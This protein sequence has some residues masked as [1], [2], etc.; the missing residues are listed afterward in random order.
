[1]ASL[2]RGRGTLG[3][4]CNWVAGEWEWFR[5]N[6]DAGWQNS[7]RHNLSLNKAF[8]K[9]PR[10]PEDDPESKGSVWIIDP[11]EGPLFEEKQKR[12]AAKSEGKVKNAEMK[13]ER[14]RQK[15]EERAKKQREMV[16][17]TVKPVQP[18][19]MQAQGQSI[20]RAMAAGPRPIQRPMAAQTQSKPALNPKAKVT[21]S[22]QAIT[23]ALRAKSV[24]ATTDSQ[25]N[26]LPFVCDGSSL[27]LDTQTFGH[28]TTEIIDK[29]TLLGAAGAVD[30][31]SAWVI[32]KSKQ[33]LAKQAQNKAS[34]APAPKLP[35][36]VNRPVNGVAAK[37]AVQPPKVAPKPAAPITTTSTTT[38]PAA[39]TSSKPLPGP[40]PPG[41]SLTKVIGMIAEV[42]NAKGD[43]NIVGPNASALLRY[44]RVVGVDIDLRV[45]E[46]IWATGVV[47]PLPPK[48]VAQPGAKPGTAKLN[49][50]SPRP[51]APVP[52]P[53][54]ASAATTAQA[55]TPAPAPGASAPASTSATPAPPA[56]KPD[57]GVKRKLEEGAPGGGPTIGGVEQ[58]AKKPKL[59][60]SSA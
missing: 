18:T 49:G 30:V 41:A 59:E 13:R 15:A 39:A 45:A 10:I 2:P 21:V 52:A 36:S 40:A 17:E 56:V 48:K 60:A 35:G 58:D 28:L 20:A 57:A 26:P 50:T 8:L 37:P 19:M 38:K 6:I 47:P 34:P 4:V 11:Q 16:Q 12:D 22:L 1:L 46:R 32:N 7:I 33:Q 51:P 31:L 55:K 54:A 14:E 3:E 43:V 42:A 27:V 44:I 5:L 25:G 24:I 29:L 53:A 23:P 9:V